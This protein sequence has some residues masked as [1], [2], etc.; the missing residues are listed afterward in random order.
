MACMALT[1]VNGLQKLNCQYLIL[2]TGLPG[3]QKAIYFFFCCFSFNDNDTK[4]VAWYITI[5][6]PGNKSPEC[7]FILQRLQ[8]WLCS[9]LHN[10]AASPLSLFPPGKGIKESQSHKWCFVLNQLVVMQWTTYLS[11]SSLR[12]GDQGAVGLSEPLVYLQ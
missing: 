9:V 5:Q 1:H 12:G 4:S 3:D 8:L 6:N 10:E 2:G 11:F 7:P